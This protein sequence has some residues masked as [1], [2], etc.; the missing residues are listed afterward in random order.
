MQ[1]GER[2]RKLVDA[3]LCGRD[4]EAIKL[5][6]GRVDFTVENRGDNAIHLAARRGK[7]KIIKQMKKLGANLEQKN[8][9]G[10]VPMH[11]A[12]KGGFLDLVK[13]LKDNG[14]DLNITNNDGE[15]PLHEAVKTQTMDIIENFVDLGMSPNV[16]NEQDGD[17]PLH[18]A[19]RCGAVEAMEGLLIKRAKAGQRNKEGKK[20][21]DV[22][23]NVA[24][25]ESLRMYATMLIAKSSEY[26]QAKGMKITRHNVSQGLTVDRVGVIIH[27]IDIPKEFPTGFYCRREKA[28]NATV[29]LKKYDEESVFS[30]VY[31]IRIF[32]VNRDCKTKIYLPVFKAPSEKEQMVI[33]FINTAEE[34]KVVENAIVQNKNS[35]CELE[36]V[37]IPETTVVCVVHVRPRRE[38]NKVN[39]EG[40][41]ITSEMEKDFSLE[42]PQDS[43]EGETV[44][45]LTVFET[46][47][48]DYAEPEEEKSISNDN[49]TSGMSKD[50]PNTRKLGRKESVSSKAPD[51]ETEKKQEI[52]RNP[53]KPQ[54][55]NLLTD[56]Y[57][58]N[59]EG[60]QPKKG[61]KVKIPLCEGME[62]ED[63]V[64]IVAADETKLQEVDSLE[65]LQTKPQIVGCNLIFE[66][67][68]FSIYVATWKKKA[69]EKEERL[70]LQR[71]ISNARDKRKP[72]ALFAVV[73]HIEG[74]KHVLVVSCVVANKSVDCRQKWKDSE[75]YEEQNPPEA[76]PVPMTPGDTYCIDIDGNASLEDKDDAT[77]RKIQ[78]SQCRS[79]WQPYH[80]FLHENIYDPEKAFAHVIVSKKT[81]TGLEEA[82]RLRIKLTAPP[83]PPTPPPTEGDKRLQKA[84]KLGKMASRQSLT[85]KPFPKETKASKKKLKDGIQDIGSAWPKELLEARTALLPVMA[86]ERNNGNDVSLIGNK[87]YVNGKL[88]RSFING[89]VWKPRL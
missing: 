65:V 66:V 64:T 78:F 9:H 43:F 67:S 25:K 2:G 24:I 23:K 62:T 71:Q 49:T 13:Y 56:V 22:A 68:H 52:V 74:L 47:T 53:P 33:H 57:Q 81:D 18:T 61:V 84:T 72:A 12:A 37:L 73:K 80:L 77:E 29:T 30:D 34:D 46:N 41:V 69:A 26:I 75:G 11:Y 4:E 60:Q 48:D 10:N 88:F 44:L 45:S 1:S 3:L 55:P 50:K 36:T 31:H 39:K 70:E 17:T 14:A 8:L 87:L 28:E 58:I 21:E 16:K 51:E 82:T 7:L 83:K 19:M 63:E 76:G 27:N 20:P 5:L 86:M 89:K 15:S 79:S 54:N 85:D 6:E 32:E 40:A 38:E 42:V 35:Y 59:V